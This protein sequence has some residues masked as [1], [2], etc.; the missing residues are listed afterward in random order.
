MPKYFLVGI[1]G[2]GENMFSKRTFKVLSNFILLLVLCTGQAA[3]APNH[4]SNGWNNGPGESSISTDLSSSP[5]MFIENVGQFDLPIGSEQG[6][7]ARFQVRG[8]NSTIWLAEDALW[9]TVL[10]QSSLSEPSSPTVEKDGLSLLLPI[11][12]EGES[13]PRKGVNIRLSFVDANP[14]PRLEPFN[15]LDT[16]VS[17]FTGN[18]P[19]KWRADVPVWGGVRYKDLYP[20]IDLEISGEND[21]LAQRLVARENADLSAVLLRVEGADRLALDGGLLRLTTAVGVYALPLLQVSGVSG[22]TRSQPTISGN[23]VTSPFGSNPANV[24]LQSSVT[25]LIYSTFL[26]RSDVNNHTSVAID[27]SGAVYTSGETDSANF[28]TTP[29]AV[30]TSYNDGSGDVFVAKLNADGS[31]LIY[32]T[33][34][35]GSATDSGRAIAVDSSGAAYITGSTG[36]SDFPTTPGVFDPTYSGNGFIVKLNPS[37]SELAYAAFLNGYGSGIAVD[38]SGAAYVTGSTWSSS[39]PTTSGAFDTSFNGGKD[40]FLA[41]V[42]ASGSALIY[43]T[44]LGG[45]SDDAGWELAVDASGAAYLTGDTG[46]SDFPVTSTAF[47]KNLDGGHDAFVAKINTAGS[48]LAYA[49]LLGGSSFYDYTWDITADSNGSA[50]VT[51]YTWSADFPTTAGA[52]DINFN[53]GEAFVTKLNATGSALA[54]STF[55]GGSGGEVGNGITVNAS[56]NAYVS[57]IT[58]SSD[59]PVTPGAFDSSYNGLDDIFVAKLNASG[60][61]LNYATYLGGSSSDSY[62]DIAIDENDTVYIAGDT[63]SSDFPTTTGAFNTSHDYYDAFITKLSLADTT[64]PWTFMLYLAGDNNLYTYLQRAITDLE[65]QAA[66]P[67]VNIVVFFDEYGANNSWRFLIQPDG[68]YTIGVNKWHLGEVN[69]GDLQTLSDFVT[70]SRENYP[71][72]NY[73]L[74]IADHGSGTRGVAWDYTSNNDNL[75][76]AELRSALN[77]ATNAGMWKLDV[78]HYDTCL[79]GMLEDA[80][81]V[82]DYADYLVASENLGWSLFSYTSYT[83]MNAATTP[84]QLAVSIADTYFA[85]PSI[86]NRPRT[87]AAVD[88]SQTLAVRQAVDSLAGAMR[89]NLDSIKTYI[90]NTRSATQKFDSRDYYKITQDDEYLDLYH[91]AEKLKQYVPNSQ[92]Q[93][94]AQDVMNAITGGF[95]IA[96]H[97]QSGYSLWDSN[98]YW[99]LENSHGISIYFPPRSGSNDY[100]AYIGH[101]QFKFTV[102]SQW[103]EFLMDY[104]G[105]VGLPPED[106]DEPGIPPMLSATYFLYLPLVLR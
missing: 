106:G 9:V 31:A 74:S 18:D 87:I 68:N 86:Q 78:L 79:M 51:G 82:Q 15:R 39:F 8:G 29:G 16:H 73:Y 88:L 57:G 71:A 75:S 76:T 27:A 100:N 58:D 91:L 63:Y 43:A 28:P 69:S 97:H 96:E 23:L 98:V 26:G 6:S 52:F 17:Y 105:A 95:I 36:S 81:Q 10:E 12:S 20:S 99:D 93:S 104:F 64:K 1:F 45:G 42:N 30:D 103:D 47:D 4:S 94:A 54:Y 11:G 56:G 34:L 5:V 60:S 3:A 84:R 37:G 40:A 13:S 62:T 80:Y 46:S 90:Q 50:Y 61:A 24:D 22:E 48:A 55:L 32:A 66:N 33:F 35:G 19:A 2:F 14:H 49:T 44:Y 92:V 70:W 102:D 65:A 83:Q 72:Q 21:Q 59:F 41:K 85:H 7:G 101:Q 89:A 25:G 53:G 67:N 38:T 77:T